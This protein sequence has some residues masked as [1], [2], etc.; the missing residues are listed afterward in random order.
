MNRSSI[1][2]GLAALLMGACAGNTSVVHQ[3][4]KVKSASEPIVDI[5][6]ILI[7]ERA[8]TLVATY[9]A[10]ALTPWD[11]NVTVDVYDASI[12]AQKPSATYHCRGRPERYEQNR[13]VNG[14]INLSG[15]H[16]L[17]LDCTP[18]IPSAYEKVVRGHSVLLE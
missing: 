14:G 1:F 8:E 6:V 17:T 18:A 10:S 9:E 7:P 11:V 13:T 3:Q 2:S 15:R 12:A 4:S 16:N 5:A